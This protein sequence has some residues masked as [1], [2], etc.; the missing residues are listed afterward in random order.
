MSLLETLRSVRGRLAVII[1]LAMVALVVLL[2]YQEIDS[3]ADRER[4]GEADL[5]RLATFAA[6]AQRE[7]FL[8]A[9]RLLTLVRNSG[10]A[11]R[12]I[13]ATPDSTEAYD[14][15][16][17]TLFVL[18]ALLP[19]TSG[20]ALWD[21]DG[22]SLCSSEGAKR[23]EFNVRGHLWFRNAAARDDVT[24][25]EFELS[26]P[27]NEPSLG[28]G[29]PMKDPAN[30]EV[31][32][33]ISTGLTLAEADDALEGTDLP[34]T[35][36]LSILDQNGVVVASSERATGS[37]VSGF[38]DA[39]GALGG[40]LDSDIVEGNGRVGAGVRITDAG[41]S[42]VTVVVSADKDVL[43]PPLTETMWRDLWP[44][45]LI[46]LLTLGAVWLLA[47]RW[48]VRPVESLVSASRSLAEGR[49]GARADVPRGISEFEQL[50]A[51]FNDM[52]ETRER[53]SHAKDE[54][55]GLV[56]HEL[57]TPITTVLG[58]A[59]ILRNRGERL[60]PEMRQGALEDIHESALRLVAIIDNLLVLARLERGVELESEPLSLLRMAN[61][62][63]QEQL[64]REPARRI[65]VRGDATLLAHGGETY[66]QQV[67]AN[68][69]A[70]AVKYS[71]PHE[72]VEI[73]V[74]RGGG[75]ALVRVSDSGE[76]IEEA[77]QEAIFEPF[78]RAA[79]T[80]SFV[81][82]IG[83]GLSVCKRLVEAMGGSIWVERGS[84][85]GADFVFTLPLALEEEA[86]FV[87]DDDALAVASTEK[88]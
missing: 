82:G 33:Y 62:A 49:L 67:L 12:P 78:Y 13:L 35:G 42:N 59:E 10:T 70:N 19:G 4:R 46:A 43:A 79:R 77:E 86:A 56:S 9:E 74:A 8:A 23:G 84:D 16:T 44:V 18:D 26:P 52:A 68:L 40:F 81:E 1:V 80:S 88:V 57:K 65:L 63:A 58:N 28:F 64:R 54:F 29:V 32:G 41:D 75:M 76:G 51:A 85:G 47:Q 20:F 3:R 2:I 50:G 73:I 55:L 37:Q 60:E 24:T 45:A 34:E 6:H 53:A 7:R 61:A 5:R 27:D 39:F 25:G 66:V 69:I 14:Q 21:K 22:N 83:I 36:R 38:R 17:R 48:I 11:L 30:G 71:P 87:V 31:L 72:P 15:C